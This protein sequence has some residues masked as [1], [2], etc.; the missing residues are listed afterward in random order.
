LPRASRDNNPRTKA[1]FCN[2]AEIVIDQYAEDRGAL[3]RSYAIPTSGA[4]DDRLRS[5]Y[6]HRLAA[7]D[8]VDFEKLDQPGKV[9]YLLLRNE[10][11]YA[12]KH[13]PLPTQPTP[14]DPRIDG[15]PAATPDP[16]PD[17]ATTPPNTTLWAAADDACCG[18][19]GGS[20]K[21]VELDWGTVGI[22]PAVPSGWHNKRLRR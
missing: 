3:S 20:T 7:L 9:D 8:A 2:V 12:L 14:D 11:R 10:L 1:E 6:E 18:A 22:T 19:G 15:A 4:R 21:N 16:K 17:E 5:F 13:L